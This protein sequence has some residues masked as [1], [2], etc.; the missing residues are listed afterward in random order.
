MIMKSAYRSF[1]E[2]SD[3]EKEE[4]VKE[5]DQE[6]IIRKTRPLSPAERELWERA[7]ARRGRPVKGQGA[8]VIAV[9][10]EKGLLDK[11]DALAKK[12]RISR[13]A[14]IAR[15]LRAELVKAGEDDR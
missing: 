3:R 6:F 1:V 12:M 14:L 5:F 13:A 2:M 15:G 9:S 4:A 10:V 11:S 7:K 8:K